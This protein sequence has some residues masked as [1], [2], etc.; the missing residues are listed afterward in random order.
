[1]AQAVGAVG[2]GA[3]LAGG[4]LSARGAEQSGEATQRMYNYQAEVSRINSQIDQQNREYALNYGEIQA[5]QYGM[6]ARQDAG[7]IRAS[8]GASN[9]D[10]NSGSAVDV[11]GSQRKI[12][13][14]DLTQIRANAAKTAY[15]F[16]VKSTMDTN[17]AAL[18]V[19]AG[20]NARTA[21]HTQAMASIIGTVSSV[22]SQWMRGNQ[23]GLWGGGGGSGGSS[24][25]SGDS[26]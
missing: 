7:Q 14:M 21:G 12:V 24:H 16:D 19:M 13:A 23:Q 5:T 2:M 15:D 20:E 11:Q 18:D 3:T 25:S 22:S 26:A 10:V 8:Q 9:I 17:Q 6:K 4:L 1:M